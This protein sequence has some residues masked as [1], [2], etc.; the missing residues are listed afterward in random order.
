MSQASG[1]SF[2]IK[3]FSSA[4]LMQA[5]LSAA[6]LCVGMILIR[7]TSDA[8]YGYYVLIT[9]AVLL[10][11]SLQNAYMLPS[12]IIRI[13]DASVDAAARTDFV[14]GL[15]GGQQKILPLLIVPCLL[16]ALISWL[17]GMIDYR[18]LLVIVAGVLAVVATL[19]REFFRM[20]LL[21]HRRPNEV[22]RGDVVYVL[23]LVAGVWFGARA[24]MA[25]VAAAAVLVVAALCGGFMQ[26]RALDQIMK[27]RPQPGLTVLRGI[28]SVGAWAT[29]GAG[30]YWCYSQGYNYL[31][32][33]VLGVDVVAALAAT[34]LLMMPVNLLSTGISSFLFPTVANW[35]QRLSIMAVF[36]RLMLFAAGLCSVAAVYLIVLWWVR[37]WVFANVLH[38]TFQQRDTLLL[39]WSGI[40]LLMTVR[41]QL[42]YIL[43]AKAQFRQ[44]SFMALC[45]AI[46]SLAVSYVAMDHFGAMGALI[47]IVVGEVLSLLG[48]VGLTIWLAT[49]NRVAQP[50]SL[51][52]GASEHEAS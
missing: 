29:A 17:I 1:K 46:C 40:C 21:A 35:L 11:T 2:F 16:A 14:G 44:L 39:M 30:I 8:Q 37:D 48:I 31:V 23:L 50:V 32:A 4:I 10:M 12:L 33:G 43:P 19:F 49:G 7:N 42:G 6:S 38:K 27:P 24:P 18:L 45:S 36:R 28:F 25:A 3:M 34:R 52:S 13:N 47:G 20:V 9:N 15:L 51:Q 41:D 26:R 5:L 22:V